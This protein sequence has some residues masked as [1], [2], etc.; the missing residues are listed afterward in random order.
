[1]LAADSVYGGSV[2][3]LTEPYSELADAAGHSLGLVSIQTDLDGALRRY[4]PSR[5]TKDGQ[6]IYGLAL[7]AIAESRHIKLPDTPSDNGE[8]RLGEN[9][10]VPVTDGPFLVNFRGPPGTHRTLNARQVLRGEEELSDQLKDK[11]VFLGVSDPS[12]EDLF[13]TPFAGRE[14]MAGVEYHA[15]A[16]DTLLSGEMITEAPAY[17][18]SAMLVFLGL[19]AI[20]LGRFA[21]LIFG[22]VG[23]IG[24]LAGVFGVWM[25]AFTEAN[26]LLP[27]S[28]SVTAAVLGYGFSIT[29]RVSV[30]Q[31]E[32]QRTRAVFSRYLD[33]G[34]VKELLRNPTAA[35]L[36][37]NRAELTVLFSDIR[38]FTSLSSLL[39]P[40]EV[41]ELLNTYLT[42]M[43]EIVF[44]QGGTIDKFAGDGI[45]AFFGAPQS[46][47]DDPRRAVRTAVAMRDGIAA[48]QAQW[49]HRAQVP[50]R[51]GI[52]IDTG[53]A[54]VGNIGSPG[55]MDYTIIGDVVNLASRLQD[56]TKE[57]DTP[58]LISEN[59]Y[60]KVKDAG[61]FR[62][63][64]IT[65]IRGRPQPVDLYELIDLK[66]DPASLVGDGPAAN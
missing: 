43:T 10:S 38:G 7:A 19:V 66:A 35:R 48:L 65:A 3:G 29:D 41:V 26:Y 2:V 63:L 24:V 36:G 17:Q 45:M 56:L 9:L 39:P 64:G 22:I 31:L 59:T 4:I 47:S 60:S 49:Q 52:G 20:V 33:P 16:A 11:I 42:V 55:R 51:I 46:H 40:E 8:V 50:L 30:E 34:I 1:V 37:G 54:V 25:V 14:Q 27:I 21:R 62:N 61:E 58:I 57:Y 53:Y 12:V 44:Q 28:A 5:R 23:M 13:S 32:K 18:G 6:F 15:A